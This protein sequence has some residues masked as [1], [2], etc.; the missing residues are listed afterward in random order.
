MRTQKT[1]YDRDGVKVEYVNR[2]PHAQLGR[3]GGGWMWKVG[4]QAGRL[5]RKRGTIIINLLV[6][7]VIISWRDK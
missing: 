7:Y 5:T 2:G 1:L 6:C 4:F 3:F